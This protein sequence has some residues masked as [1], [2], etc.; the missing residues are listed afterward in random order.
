[1]HLIPAKDYV[2]STLA[3]ACLQQSKQ[4]CLEINIDDP[5][6]VTAAFRAY[7]PEG[8]SLRSLLSAADFAL[9]TQKLQAQ[10]LSIDLVQNMKP[11]LISSLLLERGSKEPLMTYETELLAAAKQQRKP[12]IALESPLA[13]MAML[14]S[15]PLAAQTEMLLQTLKNGSS[16]LD[17]LVAHYKTQNVDS[18]YHFIQSKT[19]DGD[20]FNRVLLTRRNAAWLPLITTSA[21]QKTTF[22]AIGAGHLGGEMGLIR[23]L[24]KAGFRVVALR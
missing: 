18:I 20:A 19:T 17:E 9:L 12:I 4:L 13:Q 23:L 11:I 10:G 1:V 14:D 7:L 21:Q 6:M 24:R 16:E 8:T 2:F 15:I 22:F 5:E 3:K